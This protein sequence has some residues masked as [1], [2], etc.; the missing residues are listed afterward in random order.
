MPE[1]N[2]LLP[3]GR[4]LAL[5]DNRRPGI[6]GAFAAAR[7]GRAATRTNADAGAAFAA[8]LERCRPPLQ[9][10]L[11]HAREGVNSAHVAKAL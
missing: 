11:I 5:V 6:V 2:L 1:T 10:L 9:S 7:R 4:R 8:T 3:E